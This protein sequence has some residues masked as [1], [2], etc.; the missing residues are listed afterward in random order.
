MIII[1]IIIITVII[2]LILLS[3]ELIINVDIR[4]QFAIK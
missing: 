3:Y 1:I 2:N 4:G